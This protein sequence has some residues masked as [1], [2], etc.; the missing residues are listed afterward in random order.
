MSEMTK[1]PYCT[2]TL[3]NNEEMYVC[4]ECLPKFEADVAI[5]DLLLALDALE[6]VDR[7][8]LKNNLGLLDQASQRLGLLNYQLVKELSNV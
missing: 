4:K 2:N 6:E 5:G 1:C 3:I 8:T 7:V